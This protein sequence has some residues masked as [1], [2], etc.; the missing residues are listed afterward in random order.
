MRRPLALVI[1]V[2]SAGII[3]LGATFTAH[4][5]GPTEVYGWVPPVVLSQSG[6]YSSISPHVGVDDYGYLHV[7]WTDDS[8]G[9]ADPSYIRSLDQGSSWSDIERIETD[10][11][12]RDTALAI[13]TDNSVHAC[14]WDW[15]GPGQFE[16]K[17]ARRT[18]QAWIEETV[19]ITQS[20]IKVPTVAVTDDYIHLAWS[21]KLGGQAYDLWY[22]MKDRSSDEWSEPT[23]IFDTGPAS[24]PSKMAAD[25]N[26]NL[27][28]VWQENILPDNEIMYISGTVQADQTTWHAPITLTQMLT[29]T[30]TSPDIAVAEDG[31][32][33][34]VFGVDV[35]GQDRCQ[36]V[37][38]LSFPLSSTEGISPTVIPDSRICISSQLPKYA[39]PSLSVQGTSTIHV[40]WNGKR[41]GDVWDRIYYA[42]SGDG[43]AIWSPVVPVSRDDAWPDGFP[44]VVPWG[45]MTH[46][47]FQQVTSTADNDVYYSRK[48]PFS[49]AFVLVMKEYE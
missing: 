5:E 39:S 34:T 37:Y 42:R 47:V 33:H 23:V 46:V 15:P 43:G 32:V 31:T 22:K 26:G 17:C 45:E 16:L 18:T 13:G 11:P 8:Y 7:V 36:D 35:P 25:G 9:Q 6:D 20:D 12:S 24:Q 40:L 28:L 41:A 14:W 10:A 48:L 19:V 21:N 29:P 44:D 4:A 3:V 38:H 1:I 49:S 27:H 30:A 2:L